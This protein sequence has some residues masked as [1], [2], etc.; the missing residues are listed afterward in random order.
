MPHFSTMQQE[1]TTHT[2][3]S[4]EWSSPLTICKSEV[5]YFPSDGQNDPKQSCT[6]FAQQPPFGHLIIRE[7][8]RVPMRGV[9]RQ[10]VSSQ[11]VCFKTP[12]WSQI[13]WDDRDMIKYDNGTILDFGS[14]S[15]QPDKNCDLMTHHP[16]REGQQISGW[17][18]CIDYTPICS[19]LLKVIKNQQLYP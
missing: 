14:H 9:E 13:P 3:T 19:W 2:P 4:Q 5:S 17:S 8:C 1:K 15:T 10:W 6:H 11:W 7:W 12:K 16:Q 18:C